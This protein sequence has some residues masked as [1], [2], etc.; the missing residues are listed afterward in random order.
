MSHLE[1]SIAI[2][3]DLIA[4]PTISPDSNLAMIDDLAGRLEDVGARVDLYRDETGEKANLYATLGPDRAGGI[5]LA[6]KMC[7]IFVTPLVTF[8][9]LHQRRLS[10]DRHCGGVI[11]GCQLFDQGLRPKTAGFLIMGKR[12]AVSYTHLTLPTILLV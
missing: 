6:G 11:T 1:S 9:Q 3:S 2:L 8:N 7:G 12:K 10:N 5:L 4:Y